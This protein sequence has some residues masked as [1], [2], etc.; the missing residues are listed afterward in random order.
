MFAEWEQCAVVCCPVWPSSYQQSSSA[1]PLQ[2]R[3]SALRPPRLCSHLTN[4]FSSRAMWTPGTLVL[5]AA[6]SRSVT[7][8]RAAAGRGPTRP[9]RRTNWWISWRSEYKESGSRSVS[10]Q[11]QSRGRVRPNIATYR[12][13]LQESGYSNAGIVKRQDVEDYILNWVGNIIF[14]AI[15]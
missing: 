12:I 11:S 13:L 15:S 6:R 7:P 3:G 2:S 8:S 14:A 1:S 9:W 10:W 5:C 4:N